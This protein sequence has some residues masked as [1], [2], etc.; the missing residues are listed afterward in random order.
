MTTGSR[1]TVAVDVL[2]ADPLSCRLVNT[3]CLH[4]LFQRWLRVHLR[5]QFSQLCGDPSWWQVEHERERLLQESG[6]LSRKGKHLL[7]NLDLKPV[8]GCRGASISAVRGTMWRE[9]D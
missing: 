5:E 9:F 4:Q 1:P 3:S 2:D 8:N 6:L 7:R